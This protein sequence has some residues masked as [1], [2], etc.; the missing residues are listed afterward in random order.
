MQRVCAL[1]SDCHLF[2]LSLFCLLL[3]C[4]SS[5]VVCWSIFISF[6]KTN[7]LEQPHKISNYFRMWN[8]VGS[9]SFLPTNL[10]D[11][12][13]IQLHNRFHWDEERKSKRKKNT[14]Q[15]LDTKNDCRLG[16]TVELVRALV[17]MKQRHDMDQRPRV[18]E[19]A[20]M[21]IIIYVGS[22]CRSSMTKNRIY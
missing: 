9:L 3:L 14:K 15:N 20:R 19:A 16:E 13:F 11:T 22:G 5:A 6:M 21:T 1:A 7:Q 4:L 8:G 10:F 18:W 12:N 2:S 17:R